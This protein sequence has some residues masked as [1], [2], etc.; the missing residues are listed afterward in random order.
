M[1]GHHFPRRRR[2]LS[3]RLYLFDYI[4][5]ALLTLLS[6]F[7]IFPIY[8][9]FLMSITRYADMAAATI[10]LWP[11]SID[12]SAYRAVLMDSTA[13]TRAFG[14]STF[15]TVAGTLYHLFITVSFAY[16]LSKRALPGRMLF[17]N[18]IIFTMY[19]SGGLI[20]YYLLIRTL[21]LIDRIAVMIIPAGFSAFNL[22]LLKNY[23][24]TVPESL[25]ESA[26]ID[27]ANDIVILWRIVLPV[28]TPIIATIALFAAVGRWNDWFSALLFITSDRKLPLQMVLRRVLTVTTQTYG[29]AAEM[30]MSQ[31]PMVPQ[32]LRMAIVVITTIPIMLVYPFLQKYFTKGIIMG[33]IKS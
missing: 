8:N 25:E 15:V 31:Q 27:G 12:L 11:R 20:P 13:V 19:F 14:V 6:F 16:A 24:H 3:R 29:M 23:F 26:W 4:N 5:Y 22:I 7:V 33:S 2:R 21:G 10:Y 28:T 9:V 18:L 30:R 1:A 32:A 17:L